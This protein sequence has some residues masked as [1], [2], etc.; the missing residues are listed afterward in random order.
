MTVQNVRWFP[1]GK[2][3]NDALPGDIIL[4][5]HAGFIPWCIRFGQR[6]RFHGAKRPFTWCNHAAVIVTGGLSAVAVGQAARGGERMYL[7]QYVAEDY[8]IITLADV[9]A[10]RIAQFATSTV[11]DTYNWP[12]IIAAIVFCL[13]GLRVDLG[14]SRWL[15]CSQATSEAMKVGASRWTRYSTNSP[16]TSP[17]SST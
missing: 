17:S 2:H 5:R 14:I 7:S 1:A 4:V 16:P 9:D 11:G 12:G 13:T 3:C 6:M 10:A 15:I 8:A